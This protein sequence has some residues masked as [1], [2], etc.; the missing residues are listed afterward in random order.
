MKVHFSYF[1][2]KTYVMGY[3]VLSEALSEVTNPYV[4]V[5]K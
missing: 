2:T 4:L 1:C 5:E 3:P